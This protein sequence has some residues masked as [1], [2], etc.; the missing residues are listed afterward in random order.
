MSQKC[1]FT[2][3]WFHKH[4]N[5]ITNTTLNRTL[6]KISNLKITDLNHPKGFSRQETPSLQEL[7]RPETLNHLEFN[8]QRHFLLGLNHPGDPNLNWGTQAQIPFCI[9]LMILIILLSSIKNLLLMM[10]KKKVQ[11]ALIILLR[12]QFLF[13]F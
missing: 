2:S 7:N 10:N 11:V 12:Y 6:W 13:L 1:R 9:K 4:M 5:P 8:R 3:L